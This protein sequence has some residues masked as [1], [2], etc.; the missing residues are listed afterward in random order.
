MPKIKLVPG[1]PKALT[2][3]PTAPS[4]ATP[5]PGPA[6]RPAI[7]VSGSGALSGR[8]VSVTTAAGHAANSGA[9][10]GPGGSKTV[11][12]APRRSRG[13][14][15]RRG[16][17]APL[18]PSVLAAEMGTSAPIG[19]AV[20]ELLALSYRASLPC[21]LIGPHGLGKSEIVAAA[22]AS[23]NIDCVS[24]DLCLMEPPDLVGLP[25]LSGKTT[26]FLPPDFL[27]KETG[28]GGFLLIE[29]INRAPRY[30]QACCLELLTSRRL[31]SY[32]LPEGWVPLACLNPKTDG[33]VVDLLDDALMSRFVRINVCATVDSWTAWA[34]ANGVHP[35]VIEYVESVPNS[36]DEAEGGVNPRSWT[37]A[38]RALKAAGADLL[39][40]SPDTIVTALN[41][42][43]G[44]VHTT[45]LLRLLLG[46][47]VA[48]TPAD[49][50]RDWPAC[51]AT[52]DRWKTQGRL[53]LLA[54]SM[55][56]ILRWVRP[57][58]VAEDL[59]SNPRAAGSVQAFFGNLPGDLAGQAR[60]C[61]LEL[62]YTHLIPADAGGGKR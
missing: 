39:H 22:A 41:G 51:R 24:R 57:E 43:I 30:M 3:R 38:S 25:V 47:E 35:K 44:P 23:L 52:M 1:K 60:G 21:A 58:G 7:A 16:A 28:R 54:T 18:E 50:L 19:P 45:G 29:E 36:L 56:A 2:I 61:L 27:P 6:K 53:D 40:R 48:F 20:I 55:R 9:N 33:Y 59:K 8:T 13:S 49:V 12:R 11:L 17:V 4:K 37:Y 32:V 31:N 5:K 15:A 10:P 34:R 42:L 26:M 62:G 14:S 46:T